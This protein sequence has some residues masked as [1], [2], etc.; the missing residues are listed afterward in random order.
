[1]LQVDNFIIKSCM[2]NFGNR[3]NLN[4]WNEFYKEFA[5]IEEININNKVDKI[6]ITT[7][8]DKNYSKAGKTLFNSIKRL[9]HASF[10]E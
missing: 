4:R 10:F 8:F 7:V 1:M 6:C 3:V 9:S 5:K 2:W